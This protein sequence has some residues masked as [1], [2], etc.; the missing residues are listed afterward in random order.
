MEHYLISKGMNPEDAEHVSMYSGAG[1]AD[2]FKKHKNKILGT[3]GSA[4]AIG[5]AIGATALSN[6]YKSKQ[7][8][9]QYLDALER[10]YDE[11]LM[12]GYGH[13]KFNLNQMIQNPLNY[14]ANYGKSILKK[15]KKPKKPK[16][17]LKEK[18]LLYENNMQLR[19]RDTFTPNFR[20]L[21]MSYRRKGELN[22][23]QI[24]EMINRVMW[25]SETEEDVI[26][27][28]EQSKLDGGGIIDFISRNKDDLLSLGK[29]GHKLYKDK[30]NLPVWMKK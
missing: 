1:V 10:G 11:Q 2:W 24:N 22:E 29:A 13:T 6:Q 25:G 16:K 27:E 15:P 4:V 28:Y 17:S 21:I 12:S 14:L 19:E 23:T 30:P 20:R 3:L 7:H 26:N 18:K 8:E 9:Q 5:S